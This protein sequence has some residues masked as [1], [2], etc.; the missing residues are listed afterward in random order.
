MSSNLEDNRQ[1]GYIALFRSLQN[2]W[3]YPNDREFTEY[4]AWIDLILEA[5]HKSKSVRVKNQILECKRG[6]SIRSLKNW[7]DRWQWSKSKTYRFLELLESDG[8]IETVSE[9]VTTRITI[10]NYDTYQTPKKDSETLSETGAKRHQTTPKRLGTESDTN[11]NVNNAN[12]EKNVNKYESVIEPS[13]SEKIKN[14]QTKEELFEL[15]FDY[16]KSKGRHPSLHEKDVLMN[17]EWKDKPVKRIAESIIYTVSNGWF[18]LQEP[19]EEN[20][21]DGSKTLVMDGGTW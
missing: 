8:M 5:N 10:C 6:Q 15:W 16:R 18:S 4:E 9:T 21:P 19:D 1:W 11:K 13:F 12:N 20:N 3:I 7:A 17:L 14:A 2:H